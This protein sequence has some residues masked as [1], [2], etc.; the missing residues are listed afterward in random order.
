MKS[1]SIQNKSAHFLLTPEL[2]F[3]P[4]NDA[5]VQAL[6]E[7]GYE[8]DLYSPLPLPNVAAYG[9]NV[10][11][12]PVEYGK[13]WL[14]QNVFSSRWHQYQ[15][16]S[17]TAET[18]FATVGALAFWHRRSS[19]LLVDEI[20]SGSYRGDDPEYMKRLYHWAMR[21]AS[22]CIVNDESRIKLLQEYAGIIDS[23]RIM[24]YPG[25]FHKPPQPMDRQALRRQW[26][27]PEQALVLGVSGGFNETSGAEWLLAAFCRN[28]EL[29]LVV[30]A[31]NLPMFNR[32][33]L[34]NIR[35]AE[36]LH[37][38]PNRLGWEEA[39][40][41]ASAMDIGLAIYLNQAP[42]FQHMGIA[43]NRLCMFLAMGVPVITNRQ[44][45]FHFIEE[46]DCGVLV[47]NE[48]EFIE[49][50]DYIAARL[51]EM[52]ENAYR[53]AC[54]YIRA[55]ERFVELRQRIALLN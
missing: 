4:P 48:R 34:T 39:W 10:A 44:P 26:G 36:R 24:I 8:V 11:C 37:L 14:L 18:P 30:Q 31:I 46:Y 9:P 15:V 3:S 19:F 23:S 52:R 49:A 28:P 38:E 53:C 27:I 21:R 33:L 5:I 54:E 16:F 42:Q 55:A 41:T 51:P 13:R 35:G 47:D 22:F 50:I 6:L 17:G 20:K 7:C 45:S 40:A 29:Y 43:S 2:A 25:C 1:D 32:L 12:Y